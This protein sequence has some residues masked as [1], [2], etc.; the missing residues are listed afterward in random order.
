[1]MTLFVPALLALTACG[2]DAPAKEPV[3]RSLTGEQ[4]LRAMSEKL[5]KSRQLTFKV[6]RH[7]DAALID[8]RELSESAQIEIS[9]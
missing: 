2:G 9:V 7:L 1:M 8:G 5:A 4:V 3:A 6:K